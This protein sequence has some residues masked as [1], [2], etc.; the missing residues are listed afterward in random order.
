MRIFI[1]SPLVGLKEIREEIIKNEDRLGVSFSAM[2][3][4][5]LSSPNLPKEECLE[6]LRN[7]DY[8]ILIIG[9]EYGSIDLEMG[10]SFTEIEYDEA[11][12]LGIKVFPFVK[13]DSIDSW[14][15]Q[16]SEERVRQKHQ[17]FLQKIKARHILCA[18]KDAETLLTEVAPSIEQYKERLSKPYSPFVDYRDYFYAF[19]DNKERLFRHDYNF[20][21]RD[22]EMIEINDFLKSSKKVLT[23]TGRGGIGKSK[24]IY[25][26]AKQHESLKG[27]WSRFIFIKENVRFDD[28][29][30]KKIPSGKSVIV[31]EDAHRYSQLSNVLAIFRNRDLADR[32]KLI[33]TLRPS[34]CDI[35][36]MN[37]SQILELFLVQ[38]MPELKELKIKDTE[39]IVSG[40]LENDHFL[41]KSVANI[42]KDCPL[43]TTIGSRLIAEKKISLLK[44]DK[45][46]RRIILDKF[47]EEYL[48]LLKDVL[49]DRLLRY[50]AALSPIRP[51]DK[52]LIQTLSRI[53]KVH[54]SEI[55][56]K[57]GELE[58][59]GLLLRIGSLVR[60]VPDLVSDHI[61]YEACVSHQGVSTPFPKEVYSEF[62][63]EYT[64]NL[65]R[66]VS[67][68]EWRI[69]NDNKKIT[70]LDEVWEDI[71]EKFKNSN[72]YERFNLLTRIE[73]AT[74]FQPQQALSLVEY[75][76]KYPSKNKKSKNVL[77]RGLADWT[78]DDVLRKLPDI[79]KSTGYH[80][81]YLRKTCELLWELG[82]E[83]KRELNPHPDHPIRII[84]DIAGYRNP[85]QP[86]IFKN[87][88]V[89][90]L[91]DLIHR[92]DFYRHKDSIFPIIDAMLRKEGTYTFSDTEGF[93]I[94]PYILNAKALIPIRKR[95]IKILEGLFLQQKYPDAI[96]KAFLS[97]RN[98]L[99][100]STGSF[101]RVISKAEENQWVSEQIE[102]LKIV[103]KGLKK[104]KAVSLRV[105]VKKDL[106]WFARHARHSKVKNLVKDIFS[107][108][109]TEEYN[110]RLYKS[111]FGNFPDFWGTETDYDNRQKIYEEQ[112]SLSA[113]EIIQKEKVP[114][115]IF[116]KVEIA[117][118]KMDS[119]GLK[120]NPNH[121]LSKIVQMSSKIGLSLYMSVLNKPKS[122]LVIYSSS[123]LWPLRGIIPDKDFD[124]LINR[125]IAT[126]NHQIILNI[127]H[128]Y[129]W[130]G[131][132][133][134]LNASDINNLKRIK[135]LGIRDI[136][137]YLV[138]V[139]TNLGKFFP[140]EAKSLLLEV[141]V[142]SD[143]ADAFCGSINNTYGIPLS[144]FN[145]SE[146]TR[147]LNKLI[148]LNIFKGQHYHAEDLLKQIGHIYPDIVI[149]FLLKR[150]KFSYKKESRNQDYAPLP[151]LGFD[152]MLFDPL[153]ITEFSKHIKQ[154]R[155]LTLY[156]YGKDTFWLPKLFQT[157][158]NNYSD[159]SIE[160]LYEW[161]K[162]KNNKKLI[163]I[164][165]LLKEIEEDFLF[166]QCKFIGELIYEASLISDDCF[167][168]VKSNLFSVAVGVERVYGRGQ[169][170]PKLVKLK[171]DSIK[172]AGS[173][174]TTHP[175]Y[176]FYTEIAD[177]A[178][179]TIKDDL[180]RDEESSHG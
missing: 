134:K 17:N 130:G 99:N 25:E 179:K 76:M 106:E 105:I 166:K 78:H 135:S 108:I 4:S 56:G 54:E 91:K 129:A 16:D 127:L 140:A 90:F 29:V 13:A 42:T 5:F 171:E 19:L 180:N 109:N 61:L 82:K 146:L 138:N 15:P 46:F 35:V 100:Y 144:G 117:L 155:N 149:S 174:V 168:R 93:A 72:N 170:P 12:K 92:P 45:E 37:L 40:L 70:L 23:I 139:I 88:I 159:L 77:L 103:R 116:K 158:S 80:L 121:L 27:E 20:V 30:L 21:G 43:V 172:T 57:L 131:F 161:I 6:H 32:I 22:S 162:S 150:L 48:P 75:A 14:M 73:K 114:Y 163:G 122:T 142:E 18:F 97:L 125:G 65:L 176:K 2:E 165:L 11:M 104:N 145:K 47:L 68:L 153:K 81:D 36:R 110:F 86:V 60:I 28:D 95:A 74:I 112:L 55:I 167:K 173:F 152:N 66:N 49:S 107:L 141:P 31:L 10:S 111:L 137:A 71:Y 132:L 59:S 178:E 50:I 102:I 98:G 177:Y 143:W 128:A 148:K 126:K 147:L 87:C 123:L 118:K 133:P 24:L 96:T 164:S 58:N 84:Q 7:S 157:I 53:L 120:P 151:Y 85:R 154:V 51:E 175:A 136:N 113:S 3:K 26:I 101:G 39:K 38:E 64:S 34:G 69:K 44:N 124:V 83:D 67:E 8:M 1:S 89:D 156:S 160:I 94:Q 41:I 62:S 9:P 63:N 115:R 79:L 33:I 169:P 119:Y 52:V